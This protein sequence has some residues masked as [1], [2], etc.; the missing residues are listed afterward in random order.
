MEISRYSSKFVLMQDVAQKI[1]NKCSGCMLA[2]SIL[3]SI[4]FTT[5][6]NVNAWEKVYAQFK[7]YASEEQYTPHD[8]NGTIFA[9]I[10][11]SLNHDENKMFSKDLML[12]VLHALTLFHSAFDV[13][14]NVVKLAWKS[15]Q[16]EGEAE[17]FEAV[18]NSLIHKSLVNGSVDGSL[19]LHDLVREYLELKKKPIDLI[20][21]ICDQEG[22]LKQGTEL[23]AVF[24]S[25]RGQISVGTLVPIMFEQ[26]GVV[27]NGKHHI[28]W[29]LHYLLDTD[30]ENAI[31]AVYQ[32]SKATQQDAKALL[33]LMHGDDYQAYVAARV[34]VWL[35]IDDGAENLLVDGHIEKFVWF[36]IHHLQNIPKVHFSQWSDLML[37]L[38]NCRVFAT[39]MICHKPLLI[40]IVEKIQKDDHY[41]LE[42]VRILVALS[43][44]V[45]GIRLEE[46]LLEVDK[47]VMREPMKSCVLD[48]RVSHLVLDRGENSSRGS[49]FSFFE[50]KS[51][52]EYV[53]GLL[54]QRVQMRPPS[55]DGRLFPSID[56]DSIRVLE[57]LV[58]STNGATHCVEYGCVEILFHLKESSIYELDEMAFKHMMRF[59]YHRVIFESISSNGCIRYLVSVL[60]HGTKEDVMNVPWVFKYLAIGHEEVAVQL[61]TEVGVEKVVEVVDLWNSQR[62]KMLK[63]WL[64]HEGIAKGM[65]FEGSICE[66]LTRVIHQNSEVCMRVLSNLIRYHGDIVAKDLDAKGGLR[67]FLACYSMQPLNLTWIQLLQNMAQNKTFATKMVALGSIEMLADT[68]NHPMDFEHLISIAGLVRSLVEGFEDRLEI[69]LSKICIK[70]LL[71]IH[72]QL[73]LQGCFE[74]TFL[75]GAF[76]IT[77][78]IETNFDW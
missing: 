65:I 55:R 54:Q 62:G 4:L 66:L 7:Y 43:L 37:Q 67:L 39:K 30:A 24:L 33:H 22:K 42:Y 75:P 5:R 31:L 27:F 74:L 8:Y 49:E 47:D 77:R 40:L 68:L 57:Y 63:L 18:V 35:M 25:I 9:A 34:L 41:L 2:V 10:E 23:L 76:V 21:I 73:S 15:M 56:M 44:Y 58:D 19:T 28:E 72:K 59:F 53:K 16:H 61:I 3:G 38:A 17:Y 20:T 11:L 12:N 14:S 46:N 71:A 60:K 45:Q 26:V 51:L 36:C 6:K 69:L 64:K 52:L 78:K 1:L 48:T 50:P 32:F 13:P 70:D 29:M